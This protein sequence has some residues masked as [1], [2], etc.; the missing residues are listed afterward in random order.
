[1]YVSLRSMLAEKQATVGALGARR[2]QLQ[3]DMGAL[4][5][6]Q[7]QEPGI[8]AEQA[9]LSRDYDV[10][11]AQ[12]DKL[13]QDREDI[14]LR[15]DITSKT[16]AVSFRVIDPPSVPRLPAAPN[17]PILLIAVLIAALGAGLGVAFA[18]GQLRATYATTDRLAAASGLP[19]MGGF[20]EVVTP[21]VAAGRRRRLVWFAGGTGGLAA[22]CLLLLIVE[23]VQRGLTA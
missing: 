2:A 1:M 11:K 17:R 19:V 16:D 10:M 15:S 21:V 6:K 3:A 4:A 14:R 5:A 9:R 12:Y 8:A 20:S 13:L 7:V 22:C 23:F 18:L